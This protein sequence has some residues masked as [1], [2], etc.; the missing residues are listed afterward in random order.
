[1]INIQFSVFICFYLDKCNNKNKIYYSNIY[2]A[3]CNVIQFILS[4]KCSTYFGWYQHPSSG[5]QTT[6]STASGICLT[7]TAICR[8]RG[9]FETGLSV[10]WVAPQ[11]TTNNNVLDIALAVSSRN[12]WTFYFGAAVGDQNCPAW[13]L[14]RPLDDNE[15]EHISTHSAEE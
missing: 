15:I 12:I 9:R 2:P 14:V 6:V 5:A 8:Y 1:L 13:V 4:G 3:I 11:P 10:L 7:V